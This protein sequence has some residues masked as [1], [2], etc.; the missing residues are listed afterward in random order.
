MA[1]PPSS[2][3][4]HPG[5]RSSGFTLIELVAVVMI[6]GIIV[7]VILVQYLNLRADAEYSRIRDTRGKM[8]SAAV[9]ANAAALLAG[10]TGASGSVSVNGTTIDLVYGYPAAT[11]AGI[12]RAANLNGV[13]IFTSH[14]WNQWQVNILAGSLYLGFHGPTPAERGCVVEYV[15][16]AS[17]GAPPTIA[18]IGEKTV[19]GAAYGRYGSDICRA[20]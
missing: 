8:T 18:V 6:L 3:F 10:Q 16:A 2:N 5:T 7:S 14:T 15:N 11:S 9:S 13:K 17:S 4:H 1:R 20:G 12:L 19:F